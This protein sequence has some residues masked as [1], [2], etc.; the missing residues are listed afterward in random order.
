MKININGE[1]VEITSIYE[2]HLSLNG[3]VRP[4]LH[5]CSTALMTPQQVNAML[6][7]EQTLLD[8]ENNPI[9]TY[10]AYDRVCACEII[11][12]RQSDAEKEIALLRAELALK[13]AGD[14]TLPEGGNP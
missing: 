12:T 9:R 13:S 7:V 3:N 8:D 6:G 5:I 11:L 2:D 4:A 10:E 1:V 14:G